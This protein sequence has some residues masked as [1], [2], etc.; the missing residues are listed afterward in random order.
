MADI[1]D[2]FG[3]S[4]A[5]PRRK[6]PAERN[7]TSDLRS[8]LQAKG[9]LVKNIIFFRKKRKKEQTRGVCPRNTYVPRQASRVKACIVV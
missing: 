3:E 7:S 8:A 6:R 2:I 9:L 5:S 4:G 1:R